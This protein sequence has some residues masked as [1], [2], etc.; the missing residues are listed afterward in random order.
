MN[1][2]EDEI[3][4]EVRKHRAELLEEFGGIEGYLDHI[5][6]DRLRLEREGWQFADMNEIHQKQLA[7]QNGDGKP[8]A[9][10]P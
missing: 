10:Y 1:I 6:A 5:E 8:Q 4:V 9:A 7:E 2:Y 3:V